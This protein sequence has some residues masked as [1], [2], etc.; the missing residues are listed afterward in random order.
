MEGRTLPALYKRYCTLSS[1][2]FEVD[3]DSLGGAIFLLEGL[4]V[5]AFVVAGTKKSGDFGLDMRDQPRGDSI[6]C[7]SHSIV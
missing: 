6:R 4:P 5:E 1:G 2:I 3:V 7:M